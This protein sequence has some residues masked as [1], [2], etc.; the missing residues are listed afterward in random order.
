[1]TR[2]MLTAAITIAG[3]ALMTGTAQ[4]TT[5]NVNTVADGYVHDGK[6]GLREAVEA[7][8]TNLREDGCPKGSTSRD[9]IVLKDKTYRLTVPTT[10][11]G[12][13]VNGDLDVSGG[14]PLTIRGQ[15]P[16][17]TEVRSDEA[18]RVFDLQ[19]LASDL[20]LERLKFG[21]GDVTPYGGADGFGGAIRNTGG[22]LKL[23]RVASTSNKADFGGAIWSNGSL[24]MTRA[25]FSSNSAGREGG[26]IVAAGNTTI[27]RSKFSLSDVKSVTAN[28]FGGAIYV[29]G[30]TKVID[31][32]IRGSS[33]DSFGAFDAYGGAIYVDSPATLTL[34]RSEISGNGVSALTSDRDESGAGM[35]VKGGASANVVNSTF[36]SNNASSPDGIGGA[37]YN[38]G[39]ATFQHTTFDTNIAADFGD[40]IYT[41]GTSSIGRSI[42]RGTNSTDPCSGATV[43]SLGFNIAEFDDPS[44]GYEASDDPSAFVSFAGNLADH[45]G[46]TQTVALN[47]GSDAVDFVPKAA[48]REITGSRDQ[49]GFVR[50]NVKQGEKQPC[51]AGAFELGAKKP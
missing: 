1:M 10:N 30:D 50:P 37:V 6:C 21:N 48:C 4:A 35:F 24:R 16:G 51:D 25:S 8:R 31:T 3:A 23:I 27:K 40:Q 47:P 12:N 36:S 28:T 46:P 5:V 29:S 13:N 2:R 38:A 43:A 32:S 22:K 44:C 33:S 42:I 15:G 26:T 18:D 14:G 39:T 9:T 19:S 34:R 20:T 45:G 41:A 7:T 49:R 17:K 11:E